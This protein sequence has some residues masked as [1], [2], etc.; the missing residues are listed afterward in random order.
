MSPFFVLSPFFAIISGF[1]AVLI[2]GIA[3]YESKVTS[4]QIGAG[5]ASS[6]S[7]R[8]V[9]SVWTVVKWAGGGAG[10]VEAGEALDRAGGQPENRGHGS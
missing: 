8:S 6:S 9:G 3:V 2:L 5:S 1:A 10:V 4:V 7:R